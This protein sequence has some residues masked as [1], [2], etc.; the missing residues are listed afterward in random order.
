[1]LKKVKNFLLLSNFW[2]G[3][4]FLIG[5]NAMVDSIRAEQYWLAPVGVGFM[6]WAFWS[7]GR[8]TETQKLYE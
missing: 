4:F 8:N 1:M 6:V 7:R 3:Y 2:A 5:I